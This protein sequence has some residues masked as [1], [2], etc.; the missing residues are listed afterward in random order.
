MASS[1]SMSQAQRISWPASE[2][3]SPDGVSSR[4]V[5]QSQLVAKVGKPE[6]GDILEGLVP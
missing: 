3:G 2:D 5:L 6:V 4:R 1:A